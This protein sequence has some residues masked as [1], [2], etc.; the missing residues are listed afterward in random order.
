M[1]VPF[2]AAAPAEGQDP[3]Q[4]QASLHQ[5]RP[6]GLRLTHG[7]NH[8][9]ASSAVDIAHAKK[10]TIAKE[11]NTIE[12]QKPGV[13]NAPLTAKVR[14]LTTELPPLREAMSHENFEAYMHKRTFTRQ[15]KVGP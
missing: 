12:V 8:P 14:I 6:L 11:D 4:S 13:P 2:S 3:F 9:L 10:V 7:K 5:N 15:Q 1:P